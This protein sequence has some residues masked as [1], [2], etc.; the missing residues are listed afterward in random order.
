[1]VFSR[2]LL[3]IITAL[4]I[5][6]TAQAASLSDQLKVAIETGNITR[7]NVLLRN[8]D[9]INRIRIDGL[10]VVQFAKRKQQFEVANF[11]IRNGAE[12]KTISY[13]WKDAIVSVDGVKNAVD[14]GGDPNELLES[15]PLVH[16][17]AQRE[18]VSVTRTLLELGANPDRR[19]SRGQ[20]ILHQFALLEN[21][22]GMEMAIKNGVPTGSTDKRGFTY[23]AYLL[24]SQRGQK[25]YES[26]NQGEPQ[27]QDWINASLIAAQSLD[28]LALRKILVSSNGKHKIKIN[29]DLLNKEYLPVAFLLNRYA[30]AT[31]DQFLNGQSLYEVAQY[32]F[33]AALH[34]VAMGINPAPKT[35]F[36]LEVL[37]T[38]CNERDVM[39]MLA[40]GNV[41]NEYPIEHLGY[42]SIFDFVIYNCEVDQSL[43]LDYV[44]AMEELAPQILVD[45]SIISA[46]LD[47][48]WYSEDKKV[49]YQFSE[50]QK[51]VHNFPAGSGFK[52]A[53]GTWKI[54][55]AGVELTFSDNGKTEFLYI[56]GITD[57][58]MTGAFGWGKTRMVK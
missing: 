36:D 32:N 11:L 17:A 51:F 33:D 1:M 3:T 12:D 52:K 19:N 48:Q 9:D 31:P 24:A 21:R 16:Y 58:S 41:L 23:R 43:D 4:I 55:P 27:L 13:N 53:S 40:G 7:V 57:N 2:T 38:W 39:P 10:S 49:G 22:R 44:S 25:L 20:T 14:L 26:L 34:L 28:I 15:L 30:D 18:R 5:S 29:P 46:Y 35:E 56:V 47:G 8:A 37:T 42:A 45:N 6:V 50:D 54:V